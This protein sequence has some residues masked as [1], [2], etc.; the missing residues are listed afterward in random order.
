MCAGRTRGDATQP[1]RIAAKNA[2]SLI[3]KMHS[4]NEFCKPS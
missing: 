2:W 3:I 1:K 4:T